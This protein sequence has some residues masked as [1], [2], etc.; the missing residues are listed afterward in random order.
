MLL[1]EVRSLSGLSVE[2]FHLAKILTGF[3]PA[4]GEHS[5]SNG[6]HT[7][8]FASGKLAL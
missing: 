6:I 1:D 5:L 4:N 2:I 7:F 8:D 3:F